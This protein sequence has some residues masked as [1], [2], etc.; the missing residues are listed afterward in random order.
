MP[1]RR[2]QFFADQ[3]YH[4]YNRTAAKQKLFR[5]DDNYSF[6]LRRTAQHADAL[7]VTI[8]AYCLMPNHYHLLVRQGGS[9]PAGRLAQLVSNSYA[10]A[11]NRRYGT[12]GVLFEGRYRAIH[13]QDDGYLVHL[14]RYI[15][16]NPV[17]MA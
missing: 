8:I 17:R 13:V 4:I 11:Y 3:Y 7:E 15:H 1:R 16:G 12:S 5:E 6:W 9:Q 14:C 10:K 2:I